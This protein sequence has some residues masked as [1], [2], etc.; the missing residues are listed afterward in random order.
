MRRRPRWLSR[1]R[2]PQCRFP[3]GGTSDGEERAPICDAG[4]DD[5]VAAEKAEPAEASGSPEEEIAKTLAGPRHGSLGSLSS[6][7]LKIKSLC[8]GAGSLARAKA[9]E[10]RGPSGQP[11]QMPNP[12]NLAS[13]PGKPSKKPASDPEST[14]S[15]P[16]AS[17]KKP[18]KR[19][20]SSPSA[21]K[22]A[23]RSI[24]KKAGRYVSEDSSPSAAKR[25]GKSSKKPVATVCPDAAE[26][27]RPKA[28]PTKKPAAKA[29]AKSEAK[30]NSRDP[31]YRAPCTLEAEYKARMSRKSCAYHKALKQARAKGKSEA[32]MKAL[33]RAAA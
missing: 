28:K 13:G 12:P 26:A 15:L 4:D 17:S 29:K 32:E 6:Y 10:S 14:D 1:Q 16:S 2:L 23:R 7:P 31:S 33:A 18:T 3:F 21:P 24:L 20:R 9:S 11:M 8:P 27:P 5:G 22:S 30:A 19:T 25:G